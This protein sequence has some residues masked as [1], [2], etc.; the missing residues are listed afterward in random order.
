MLMMMATQHDT[1]SRRADAD[2]LEAGIGHILEAAQGHAIGLHL[3]QER[4][5]WP[6]CKKNQV[7][8]HDLGGSLV[9]A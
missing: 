1:G 4:Q 3:D 8:Q 9:D 2:H 7:H 6:R 5:P